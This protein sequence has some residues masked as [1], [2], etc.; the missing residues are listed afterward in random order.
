MIHCGGNGWNLSTESIGWLDSR[1]LASIWV[2][3]YLASIVISEK[4]L[5]LK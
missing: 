3:N 2:I 4:I 5:G 1:Y